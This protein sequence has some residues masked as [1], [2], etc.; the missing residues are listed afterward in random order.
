MRLGKIMYVVVALVLTACS[1]PQLEI[2]STS[3]NNQEAP[4]GVTPDEFKF[5]WKLSSAERNAKQTSYQI[6]LA[7]S[8]A[9]LSE[10][11][12]VWNSG[13]TESAQSIMIPYS[14]PVLATGI[15]YYW[16][17]KVTDN[18]GNVSE[19]SKPAH[20]TTALDP[21]TDWNNAQWIAL[22]SLSSEKRIVPGIH[23]PG[24]SWR[25]KDQG[26][27]KLPMLRKEF[28]IKRGLEKAHIFISG[29][30]QYELYLNGKKVGNSF[31]SPGWTHYDAFC[32]YNTFDVT[33]MLSK[34]DNTI[35]TML[36]NGFFI[37][38]N[39][40]YRKVMTAY[41]NPMMIAKLRLEYADGS[42]EEVVTDTSWKVT[43]SPVTF[44]SI[45]SGETYNANLAQEG[46]NKTGF[47]DSE[48]QQAITVK[49]PSKELR[50]ETDYPVTIGQSL[51]AK[52]ITTI[53]DT[54]GYY[55]YD[56]G[57]NASA[58]ISI[59]V[60]GNKGDTV[61]FYPAEL[62]TD[63]N[64]AL[65]KAT[66]SP[67]YFTYIL[68]GDDVETWTPM[69]TYYGFRYVEVR[70]AQPDTSKYK[71]DMP[72]LLGMTMEHNH[73]STPRQGEFS[74]SFELFNQINTLIDWAIRSN[75]QSVATDCPHREK[76]GWL[77]QLLLM[78]GSLHYSYDV[79]GL[80]NKQIDD[81]MAAQTPSGL[82]PSIV[83]EYTVF[84]GG[85]RDSPEWGSAA[86]HLP[87]LLYKWYGDTEVI[88]RSWDMM[89][90]YV[91][92]LRDSSDNHIID[93]GLGDW[94]DQGPERPG[95]PQLT[96]IA[97]TATAIYY[98]DLDLLSK[99]AALTNRPDAQLLYEEQAKEVKNAFNEKFFD[100]ETNIYS[101]GSQTA[102]AMP[103]ALGLVEDSVKTAVV[104]TLVESIEA[105]NK[106]LTA[107]DIGFHYLVKALQDNGCGQ[108]LFEMNASDSVPGY[109]YQLKHGATALTESWG[110]LPVV[111]N[112]HLM[113]GHIMEW[114][115][116]GLLG[117]DQTE[118][119]VAYNEILI[120]PNFVGDIKTSSGS[121]ESPY[122]T[123]TSSWEKVDNVIKLDVS[124]P[125]NTTAVVR[126]PYSEGQTIYE[127]GK[128]IDENSEIHFENLKDNEVAM[129]IGSGKYRF[130]V[131]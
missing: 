61:Y 77:E 110:A 7:T 63:D 100:P 55:L 76:L 43:E 80:Y 30:G 75:M 35:G 67:Y 79:F 48:W 70:G 121:F 122:G 84:W 108:L 99:M 62:K 85:F 107:G 10:E 8:I 33:D 103:L 73:N 37:V 127:S 32:F 40:R 87:W 118:N 36:G 94:Y 96:P 97:L 23:L 53:N 13:V 119:S 45:Y 129:R 15:D 57:Q 24:K 78:G 14:G 31:L 86:I 64:R 114:F 25:G 111:S 113:L 46:W 82:V 126:L 124:I 56:F 41:G 91:E 74:T 130:E 81:M 68:K 3:C 29:L 128:S 65:Q 60:K 90:H 2:L 123:I 51:N 34:G 58:I 106:A 50:P 19:W 112:N 1:S 47:D 66:G 18:H 20:F 105:G 69:F 116:S 120:A 89:V 28:T 131:K 93:Y 6:V 49:C 104:Q 38:P 42:I 26:L 83:P 92:Y 44:S 5:G 21:S 101:T 4:V 59:K 72:K 88:N 98:S 109:G 9:D 115:Y 125:F 11:K 27:H 22:D 95:F 12:A 117:I 39:S 52:S 102:I 16:K 17:V 54:T 71:S